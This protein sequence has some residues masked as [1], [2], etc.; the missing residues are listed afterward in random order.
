MLPG[1]ATALYSRH[2][3]VWGYRANHLANIA[4]IPPNNRKDNAGCMVAGNP[5]IGRPAEVVALEN[6]IGIHCA[7][8]GSCHIEVDAIRT[9]VAG[10]VIHN[11][12][13]GDGHHTMTATAS[14]DAD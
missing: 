8:I 14:R 3:P 5:S 4:T 6:G 2:R 1:I 10:V 7:I 11:G 13:V 9:Y 12:S